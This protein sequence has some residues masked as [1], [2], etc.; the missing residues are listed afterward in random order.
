MKKWFVLALIAGVAIGVQAGD[1]ADKKKDDGKGEGKPVT[2]EMF[3][4]NQKKMAEKKGI[5]FDQ[6]A[7]E[8]KFKKMDKNKDGKLT[9]DEVPQRKGK[10]QGQDKGTSSTPA[11]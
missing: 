11:E 5:E 4:A 9:G 3:V 1:G 6:A 10:G 8:A 7:A 2:K